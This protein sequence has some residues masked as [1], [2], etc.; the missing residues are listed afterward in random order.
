MFW[1]W[2]TPKSRKSWGMTAFNRI[3]SSFKPENL[4]GHFNGIRKLHAVAD[5]SLGRAISR[6][7]SAWGGVHFEKSMAHAQSLEQTP[8]VGWSSFSRSQ[9]DPLGCRKAS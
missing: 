6:F 4:S 7:L 5:F 1:T 8:E 2:N 3:E 9:H